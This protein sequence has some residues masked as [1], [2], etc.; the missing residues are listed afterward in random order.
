MSNLKNLLIRESL[1]HGL[2]I[3]CGPRELTSVVLDMVS[4]RIGEPGMSGGATQ[5]KWSGTRHP[6]LSQSSSRRHPI[7]VSSPLLCIDSGNSFNPYR[8]AAKARQRGVDAVSLLRSIHVARPLTAFQFHEMLAKVP[9]ASHGETPVVVISDLMKLFYDSEIQ[10]SDMERAFKKFLER[11]AQ[12]KQRA[13]V[14]VLLIDHDVPSSRRFFLPQVLHLA[15]RVVSP[16]VLV[17]DPN[18]LSRFVA[19]SRSHLVQ[20]GQAMVQSFTFHP[21]PRFSLLHMR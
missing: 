17:K 13:V 19:A 7:Q 5:Q 1:N 2:Y 21:W 9:A 15:K 3:I 16:S 18:A 20:T 11:L 4:A 8:V 12:L 10:E 14:V 6:W